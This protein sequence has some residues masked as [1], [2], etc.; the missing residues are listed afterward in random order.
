MIWHI[1]SECA[2]IISYSFL[3]ISEKL[4]IIN[5]EV[6]VRK[7]VLGSEGYYVSTA[8]FNE[9]TIR[10]YTVDQEKYDIIQDML[11]VKEYEGP[12]KG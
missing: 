10:K 7:P 8:G 1:Q 4:Y 3:S 11:S 6:Q 2:D 12:F 5:F 9:A